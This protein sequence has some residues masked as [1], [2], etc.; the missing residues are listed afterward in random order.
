MPRCPQQGSGPARTIALSLGAPTHST[1]H[2][3]ATFFQPRDPRLKKGLPKKPQ[4][5]HNKGLKP[6]LP[7]SPELPVTT[8][9]QKPPQRCKGKVGVGRCS[10][11]RK[12]EGVQ[13]GPYPA[14]RSTCCHW[15]PGM[16]GSGDPGPASSERNKGL[17]NSP[18]AV[19][20]HTDIIITTIL[21][22]I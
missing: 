18:Q 16:C 10:R 21:A 13:T 4:T 9:Q 3:F 19:E 6:H 15:A 12:G 20:V 8:P 5:P 2:R 17:T 7:C 1:G 14:F 11:A 22:P